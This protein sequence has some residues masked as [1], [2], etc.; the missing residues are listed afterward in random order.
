M[1][2]N[3]KIFSEFLGSGNPNSKL[4]FAGLEEGGDPVTYDNLNYQ[5]E[6]CKEFPYYFE[7]DSPIPRTGVWI[8]MSK[9]LA[10]IEEKTMVNWR[11]YRLKLFSENHS[12][13]F[14][15]E[16]YPLPKNDFKK[17][18]NEYKDIFGFNYNEIDQYKKLMK[19]YRFPLIKNLWELNKPKCTI[20]FGKECWEDF[21]ELFL[22][23]DE[24]KIQFHKFLYYKEKN[25]IL[26]PFFRFQHF[27]D[28]DINILTELINKIV[29]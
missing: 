5:L 14:L 27:S 24:E 20:C 13:V 22:L 28:K 4:W 7:M 3:L 26:T 6:L 16:L 10:N 1:N 29:V 18:G 2:Q 25:I 8:I 23:N 11:D 12:K 17:W 19:N 9:I 21:K 15:T